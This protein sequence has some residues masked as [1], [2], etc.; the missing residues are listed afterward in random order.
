MTETEVFR[1]TPQFGKFY[2]HAEYTCQVGRYPNEKYYT[3]IPPRYVGQLIER[4]Q[5]GWGDGSW[6]T[7]YFANENG[8]KVA[9]NYSYEGRTSFREVLPKMRPELKEAIHNKKR[10]PSL[11][12]IAISQLSTLDIERL[13]NEEGFEG[14]ISSIRAM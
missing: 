6:R 10:N 3:N 5:G 2:E 7:D 12:Q 1:M 4:A 9:V 14:I 11:M 8:V 13:R